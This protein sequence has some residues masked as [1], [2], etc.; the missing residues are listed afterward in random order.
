MEF[1]EKVDEVEKLGNFWKGFRSSPLA[2]QLLGATLI[3]IVLVEAFWDINVILYS[4]NSFVQKKKILPQFSTVWRG[5]EGKWDEFLN[6][7]QVEL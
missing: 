2:S 6:I 5:G 3:K 1:A 4:L 7:E